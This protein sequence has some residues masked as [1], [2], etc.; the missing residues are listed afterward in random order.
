MKLKR[1]STNCQH[2]HA[3]N[4]D[5]D[6]EDTMVAEPAYLNAACTQELPGI[7]KLQKN[8]QLPACAQVI[9]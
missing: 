2:T 6:S 3:I 4:P 8:I 5:N 9:F 1:T 7:K